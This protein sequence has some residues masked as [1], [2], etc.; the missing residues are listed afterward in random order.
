MSYPTKTPYQ[1]KERLSR[2]K[3]L[4]VSVTLDLMKMELGKM[5]GVVP[6]SYYYSRFND[7]FPKMYALIG[8]GGLDEPEENDYYD[9]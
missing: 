4:S 1:P 3:E 2:V 9:R 5:S 7:L 6:S 8:S